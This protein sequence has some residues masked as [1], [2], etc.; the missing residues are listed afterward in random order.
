MKDD[1]DLAFKKEEAVRF[2][3]GLE[4]SLWA[5]WARIANKILKEK[6]AEGIDF[7]EAEILAIRAANA[8]FGGHEVEGMS[9]SDMQE[10]EELR[11]AEISSSDDKFQ[12]V[13][14]IGT[15]FD[16][17]YG[18]ITLTK[19]FMQAM[20]KNQPA[21]LK[22][23]KPFLNEQHDRGKALGWADELRVTEEGLEVKWDFTKLGRQYIEDDVYKYYSGEVVRFRDR[24]TGEMIYPIFGGAALTNS[25]VMKGMPEAHLTDSN[26]YSNP[27]EGPKD[28]GAENMDFSKLKEEAVN[29]SDSEKKELGIALGLENRDD[30]VVALTDK[31][32]ALNDVTSSLKEQNTTLTAKLKEV[33]DAK[34]EAFLSTAITEGKVKPTDKDVWKARLDKDYEDYST[35]IGNLP[36]VVDLSGPNGSGQDEDPTKDFKEKADD[37]LGKKPEK[38]GDK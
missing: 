2:K 13:I 1:T 8:S 38:E 27:A 32:S 15:T 29:L 14:P 3:K 7:L 16:D 17:W 33:D 28:E 30:E 19:A 35:I 37:F 9:F 23:T 4:E 10:H 24:D 6:V 11:L 18:E 34:V 36:V 22:N 20:I 5:K 26:N 21:A 31:V 12:L 25:P